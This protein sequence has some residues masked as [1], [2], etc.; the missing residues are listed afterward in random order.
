MK[1]NILV[2]GNFNF[3]SESFNGQ[4]SKTRDYYYCL[5]DR[6]GENSVD[7]FDTAFC[8]KNILR[9]FFRLLAKAKKSNHIVLLLGINAAS[10]IVPLICRFKAIFG[11]KVFWSVVGGAIL[12]D[13]KKQKKLC[14]YM[15][16]CKAV[17]F[18]TKEMTSYFLDKGYSNIF[19]APVFTKRHLNKEFLPTINEG[20]IRACT[21]S[22]VCKE[23]GI[24]EAILAVKAVNEKGVKCTLDI[25][26]KPYPE[27]EE[28]FNSL[29]QGAENYIFCNDYLSGDNVID[30]LSKHDLMIFPT[31]Y[32]GEGFPIGVVECM[33][34]GVPVIASDWHYNKEIVQDG[35]NGL[36]FD[37][38]DEKALV[39]SL[40]LLINDR[41]KLLEMRFNSLKYSENFK[42]EKVLSNL[43]D[44]I[45]KDGV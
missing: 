21:Y 10:I 40:C 1:K 41:E 17:Y 6:F 32:S 8:R 20:I 43:F 19:Y 33:T 35:I 29:I 18:E 22:R 14:K 9:S 26:G 45:E 34:A 30:T 39:K 13:E 3:G 4:T 23:K 11:Y 25:Y 15:K 37:L 7:Y 42:P 2:V 12:F 5:R 16:K 27:Y 44:E 28:E 36:V 31:F 38:K 24:S